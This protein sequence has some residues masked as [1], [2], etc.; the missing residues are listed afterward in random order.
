M[1]NDERRQKCTK[2]SHS[3]KVLNILCKKKEKSYLNA[4]EKSQLEFYIDLTLALYSTMLIQ[5]N[6]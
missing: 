3:V 1:V 4:N 6:I 2:R 5:E